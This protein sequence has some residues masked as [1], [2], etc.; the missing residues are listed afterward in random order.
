MGR[1]I[2]SFIVPYGGIFKGKTGTS[3]FFHQ[4]GT[5]TNMHLFEVHEYV[6]GHDKVV[7][8]GKYEFRSN[9]TGEHAISEWIVIFHFENDESVSA[10]M[11]YNTS[12]V[13]K[14]FS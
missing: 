2:G 11:Y 7:A 4:L 13:E 14:A 12:D 3:E 8:T 5:N 10:R 9:R 6:A 1:P